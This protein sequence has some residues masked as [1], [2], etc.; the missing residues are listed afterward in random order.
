MT[1]TTRNT[2]PSEGGFRTQ[3]TARSSHIMLFI[4]SFL[5]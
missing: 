4:A 2:R 3:R 5:C 1:P